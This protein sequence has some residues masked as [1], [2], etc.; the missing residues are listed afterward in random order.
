MTRTS[1]ARKLGLAALALILLLVPAAPFGHAQTQNLNNTAGSPN[2]LSSPYGG[3]GG[4]GYTTSGTF[5]TNAGGSPHTEYFRVLDRFRASPVQDL[6]G[7]GFVSLNAA[8]TPSAARKIDD[9][10][11]LTDTDILT[12]IVALG[13]T[14]DKMEADVDA[15]LSWNPAFDA[16]R[17]SVK[18]DIDN[19]HYKD[20]VLLLRSTP[21]A[22]TYWCGIQGDT[23]TGYLW[24]AAIPYPMVCNAAK[25]SR[26][27]AYTALNCQA[28]SLTSPTQQRPWKGCFEPAVDPSGWA[29]HPESTARDIN[30]VNM[31]T[32]FRGED[33]ATSYLTV[34]MGVGW[35]DHQ[36][37]AIA[38]TRD[39]WSIQ[40]QLTPLT[41]SNPVANVVW[42]RT[43][44]TAYFDTAHPVTYTW[45]YNYS[46]DRSLT[47]ANVGTS[48]AFSAIFQLS[49]R[50]TGGEYVWNDPDWEIRYLRAV[51]KDNNP[52]HA[53]FDL[54][55]GNA[56][57][58]NFWNLT[59]DQGNVVVPTF[60]S[61][62]PPV[63]AAG[64]KHVFQLYLN[65]ST[66]VGARP[67]V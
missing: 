27:T 33:S 24:T 46:L 5:T 25:T 48:S 17:A 14:K 2:E 65:S 22:M 7:D 19:Q 66:D 44:P 40:F 28:T 62:L 12:R 41:S 3:G 59:D 30:L 9:L 18:L 61:G 34:Q 52:I 6:D 54:K 37:G 57:Q 56:L 50:D 21:L 31:T 16:T 53:Y 26:V 8:L 51:T 29:S 60:L 43:T 20:A 23:P 13:V 15:G 32:T 39:L 64:T 49:D 67:I 10:P 35:R 1:S 11:N 45:G 55:A 58:A 63:G 47:L 42:G 38:A 4:A 36:F